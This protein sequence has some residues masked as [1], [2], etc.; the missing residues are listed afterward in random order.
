MIKI[1]L[2]EDTPTDAQLAEYQLKKTISHFQTRVVDNEKDLIVALSEFQPDLVISDYSMPA[3]NGMLALKTVQRLSPVT[4]V[5]IFTG[6]MNEDV[7]VECMKSG[8]A[9]YVIKEHVKRLGQ[10]V[11]SALEQKE[12]K[13]QKELAMAGLQE[14]EKKYRTLYETMSQGVIYHGGDGKVISVN[15]SVERILGLP[16]RQLIGQSIMAHF[17]EIIREDGT[18]MQPE[19]YPSDISL[20]S[21]QQAEAIIAVIH[22]ETRKHIWL[23]VCATPEFREGEERPFQ[24]YSTLEDI[25]RLKSLLIE[26]NVMNKSLEEQVELRTREILELSGLHLSILGNAGLAIVATSADG[27]IRLFN[28]AAEK[29]LGYTA[30]E[31][32]GISTPML[33]ND[34][35]EI[36]KR[37]LDLSALTG[38]NILPV[39]YFDVLVRYYE[40]YTDECTYLKKDG[41]RLPVRV[42]ISS[43]T[44]QS[45]QR[46]G[47]ILI[48]RDIT[49]EILAIEEIRRSEER[50]QTMFLDHAAVMMLISPDD[51][52]I[53]QANKAARKFYGY[54]FSA[55]ENLFIRHINQVSPEE[56]QQKMMEAT[57]VHQ[58][59]FV[60]PHRLASGEIRTVEVHSSP[61]EVGG[62]K[63]LFSI[64]HD[65]T[66]RKIA[67]EKLISSELENRAILNAVP[68]ILFKID[69]QGRFR[70]SHY[71]NEGLP[72]LED[73]H[74]TGKRMEEVLPNHVAG[75]SVQMMQKAFLTGETITFEYS[76]PYHGSL[77]YYENRMVAISKNEILSIIRDITQN[78]LV[79][80][81]LQ[82]NEKLLK[83]MTATSPQAFLVVDNRTDEV[84]FFNH[85][86]CEI[87]NLEE[88]EE[89]ITAKQLKFR[90]LIRLCKELASDPDA[91][92]Q[93]TQLLRDI[94]NQSLSDETI[95][96]SDG[97]Y[98]HRFSAQILGTGDAY[99][100]RLIIYEDVTDKEVLARSLREAAEHER[101][102]NEMKSKFVS[103]ASHEFRT[104][105]ASVLMATETLEMYHE[106]L[107]VTD[108]VK[109]LT[110]IRK[111]IEHLRDMINQFMSLSKLE[112]GKIPI[113]PEPVHMEAFVRGWMA[114]FTS[115][116]ELSH[117]IDYRHEAGNAWLKVDRK[118]MAQVLDNLALNS[119]KYSPV[120]KT[121]VI[122]TCRDNDNVNIQVEDQG[123]GIPDQDQDKLFEPFYRASNIGDIQGTGL[124]LS[125][126]KQIVDQHQG[127][128]TVKSRLG[129]GTTFTVTLPVMKD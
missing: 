54:D 42:T 127:N 65:I 39:N 108:R 25:T 88:V 122:R 32:V 59:C 46:L 37:V 7:A 19:E 117:T 118:L 94:R 3:F 16:A 100:G 6:S 85:R 61:I 44:D 101:Q 109:Y 1:L 51:G 57:D 72:Y 128:I 41:S 105:L 90:D 107:G 21:G 31:V 76:L 12:V 74:V 55:E 66:E 5:I 106:K 93:T 11:L 84:L 9:D 115:Q 96:L 4:P 82:R 45:G 119:I 80:N 50:F 89:Q 53:I 98:I 63:V 52:K 56:L 77:H 48:F 34:P 121:V 120:N 70:Y 112:L 102:M 91:Y 30:G 24:V 104:P 114:E 22:P 47:A 14:S 38:E 13:L 124:G 20:M 49:S 35:G 87:W 36:E 26:L 111:S 15:G 129:Q 67:Q 92:E 27:M 86:Y 113:Q 29:L 83:M 69:S 17:T 103:M 75:L 2:V 58:N 8:A 62:E 68:D 99:Y 125:L 123:I 64:I 10:A 126:C 81:A 40:T 28:P 97:R 43:Y 110:R 71:S 18:P 60:F 79:F 95:P 73:Q 78:T 23:R 116:Q 33:F